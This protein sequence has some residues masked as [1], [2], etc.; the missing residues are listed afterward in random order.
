MP[1]SRVGS[2][3]MPGEDAALCPLAGTEQ[4][5]LVQEEDASRGAPATTGQGL[6]TGNGK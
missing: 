4:P 5:G 3:E 2:R 1:G 6:S